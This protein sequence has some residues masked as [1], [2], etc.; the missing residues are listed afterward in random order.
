MYVAF[1]VDGWCSRT[2]AGVSCFLDSMRIGSHSSSDL[3]LP[4]RSYP[5]FLQIAKTYEFWQASI[6]L[7][8]SWILKE[9]LLRRVFTFFIRATVVCKNG[10]VVIL[11][12]I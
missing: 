11:S 2:W 10:F 5:L 4:L 3:L 9:K 12:S 8:F 7:K 1:V 6:S